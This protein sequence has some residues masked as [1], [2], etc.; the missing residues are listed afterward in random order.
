MSCSLGI[1]PE[2]VVVRPAHLF[3]GVK[4]WALQVMNLWMHLGSFDSFSLLLMMNERDSHLMMMF[5]QMYW[6]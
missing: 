3:D 5:R 2:Q 1:V 4:T 6:R